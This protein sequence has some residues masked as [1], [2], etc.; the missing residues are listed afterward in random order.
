MAQYN[1]ENPLI[2]QSDHT[3][4]MEVDGP[5]YAAARDAL[6]RFTDFCI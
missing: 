2:V 3:V 6:A 5:H 4:L 1:P